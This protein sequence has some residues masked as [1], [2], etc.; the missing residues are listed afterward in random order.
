GSRSSAVVM[1]GRVDA[2]PGATLPTRPEQFQRGSGRR[3]S[4]R[5]LSR[6]VRCVDEQPRESR[7]RSGRLAGRLLVGA[8]SAGAAI[9]VATLAPHL[10]AGSRQ[11]A[12]DVLPRSD[13][14]VVPGTGLSVYPPKGTRLASLGTFLVDDDGRIMVTIAIG[15]AD[16]RADA[17]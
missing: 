17:D 6:V 14:F 16:A 11:Q 5:G 4:E 9:G 1:R 13:A 2:I 10:L 12:A 3:C 8:V 15:R 7:S